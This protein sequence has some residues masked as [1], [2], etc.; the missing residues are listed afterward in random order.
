MIFEGILILII[1]LLAYKWLF[2]LFDSLP[3][4]KNKTVL[5]T[6]CDSGFGHELALKCLRHD[7]IVFAGCLTEK[8]KIDKVY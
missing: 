1:L 4:V 3:N 2:S 5:I 6:G 7:M 8:V